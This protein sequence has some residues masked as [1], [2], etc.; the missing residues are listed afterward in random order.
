MEKA[1]QDALK[2]LY[3]DD[4]QAYNDAV[5]KL[6]GTNRSATKMV[7]RAKPSAAKTPVNKPVA[8][9]APV[10]KPVAEKVERT[11]TEGDEVEVTDEVIDA[12]MESPKFTERFNAMLEDALKAR[13]A[14]PGDEEDETTD[15]EDDSE[16]DSESEGED[17]GELVLAE[18]R[19]LNKNVGSLT[20]RVGELEK[21][22]DASVQ[23]VLNDLPSRVSRQQIIRPRSGATHLPSN[24]RTR[25][26]DSEDL[27]LSAIAES[28]LA[29]MGE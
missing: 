25:A 5:A 28:T 1:L 11:E 10:A 9:S 20:K 8:K 16:D 26:A 13:S 18:L 7:N 6:D 3:G 4:E 15:N 27:D 17:V 2:K 19:T 29:E 24:V 14:D 21:T 23:E 12:V 22:R